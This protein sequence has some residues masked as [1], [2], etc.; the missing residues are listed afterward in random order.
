MGSEL[1]TGPNR[2][3]QPGT[4]TPQKPPRENPRRLAPDPTRTRPIH[5]DQPPGPPPPHHHRRTHQR[6]PPH[7]R[8]KPLGPPD[9]RTTPAQPASQQAAQTKAKNTILGY[10]RHAPATGTTP[11]LNA[12]SEHPKDATEALTAAPRIAK[13]STAPVPH[14][15]PAIG[16]L[17]EQP[18]RGAP[19]GQ[20]RRRQ[21]H[22][23]RT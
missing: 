7:P 15:E 13:L 3:R 19:P 18:G 8:G 4:F 10:D 1:A 21:H 22:C 23:Y 11:A 2:S 16:M 17:F 14:P 12:G 20:R 6:L 5:L 9:R